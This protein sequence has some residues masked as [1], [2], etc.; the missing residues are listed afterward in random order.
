MRSSRLIIYFPF[1]VILGLYSC[2]NRSCFTDGNGIIYDMESK[3]ALD[4]VLVESYIDGSTLNRSM[5]TDSTGKFWGTTGD[6]GHCTDLHI[7]LSKT[8]YNPQVLIN[9]DNDTIYLTK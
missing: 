6:T 7:R 4:S 3:T 5:I 9:P 1:F 8:G 2:L